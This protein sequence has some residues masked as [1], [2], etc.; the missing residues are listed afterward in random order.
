MLSGD[1]NPAISGEAMKAAAG[2]RMLRNIEGWYARFERPISSASLVGGF[3]FDALT[4]HR[5][6]TFR[7]NLWVI[8]H[9]VVV[10]ACIVLVNRQEHRAGGADDSPRM[11]FW[12]I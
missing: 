2:V 11:R 10:G 6:D 8:V 4:L 9:L 7:E 5:V 12:L 1:P 3:V